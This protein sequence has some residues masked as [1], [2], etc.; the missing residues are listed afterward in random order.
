[1]MIKTTYYDSPMGKLWLAAQDQALIGVWMEG[2][3]YYPNTLLQERKASDDSLILHQTIQWLDRYFQ[4]KQPSIHE[5]T[6]SLKGSDFQK[7]VWD[8]LC[9]IPYGQTTTYGAISKKI[10]K[11]R[12]LAHMSAQAVGGA[13]GHNPISIII[14][15]HRVVGTN[16]SLVGYAGGMDRKMALLMHEGVDLRQFSIPKSSS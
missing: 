16:G 4:K 12:G 1:M 10:A 6:I 8:I 3:K 15:C 7:E 2:Q 14:P 13:V 9:E 5:L 11:K